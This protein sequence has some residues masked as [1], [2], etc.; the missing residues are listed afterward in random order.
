MKKSVL[1]KYAELVVKMGVNV[2]K[3]QEVIPY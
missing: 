1:K 3:G 2:Q